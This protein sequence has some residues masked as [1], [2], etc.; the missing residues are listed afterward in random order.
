MLTTKRRGQGSATSTAHCHR[1]I[2][3]AQSPVF[4]TLFQQMGPPQPTGKG[5]GVYMNQYSLCKQ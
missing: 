4:S 5:L 3:A 1:N 2:L